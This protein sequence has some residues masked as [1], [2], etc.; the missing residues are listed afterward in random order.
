MRPLDVRCKAWQ[1]NSCLQNI[2]LTIHAIILTKVEDP[3][4]ESPAGMSRALVWKKLR[5]E[6][7]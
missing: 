2:T 1:N 6:A 5:D 3:V 7:D 4:W